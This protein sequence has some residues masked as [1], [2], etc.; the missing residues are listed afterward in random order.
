[1][2]IVNFEAYFLFFKRNFDRELQSIIQD[3]LLFL[4]YFS[5]SN[6]IHVTLIRFTYQAVSREASLLNFII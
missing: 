5:L 6:L 3:Y 4:V 1:M 2:K